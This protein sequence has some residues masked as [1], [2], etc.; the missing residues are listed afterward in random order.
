MKNTTP[1]PGVSKWAEVEQLKAAGERLV[2]RAQQDPGFAEQFLR[3]IGYYEAMAHQLAEQAANGA[4]PRPPACKSSRK[5][6]PAQHKAA[7]SR[8]AKAAE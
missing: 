4:P 8:P 3:D 5:A 1:Q 6:I 7:K 2:Q